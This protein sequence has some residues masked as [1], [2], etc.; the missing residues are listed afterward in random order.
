MPLL[1]AASQI[2]GHS[3]FLLRAVPALF[4]AA[5]VYTTCLLATEFGG[6]A[7]AELFAA[8]VAAITPVLM[9]FGTTITT[10]MVGLWLW[11]LAALCILRIVK[12]A[13]PRWWLAAGAIVG[14]A[15]ESKYSVTFFVAAVVVALLALPQRRVL[16][17]PWFFA[18]VALA[19]IIALPNFLWQA[20]HGYPMWTLLRD[21]DEYKNVQLTPLQYAATQILITHPLLAPV[22]LI[23][24]WTLLRRTTERF[25]G[26]AYLLLIAQISLLH[27]KHYY[28]GAVYPILI[29]AGAVSIER[30]TARSALWRPALAAYALVA[31]ILLVPLLMPVLPERTMSAYDRVAQSMLA[32]EVTLARTDGSTIGNLPPDWADMHG[33]R[34]LAAAVARVYHSLPPAQRA[35]AGILAS[36]YGEAAAID[37]FGAQYGLPPVISGHN[38]Y[39]IWGTRGYSGNVII[40]VHGECDRDARL[41]RTYRV[42]TH[43]SNPW[44]RPFENGFPISVCEGITTPLASFW[45]KLR[46]YN[47]I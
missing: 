23:G 26:V 29:A 22:W 16:A 24:L 36:N 10:D 6:A 38:Q 35:Q 11:P 42:A 3:L 8:L 47:Q 33:W 34:E 4:A 37:F 45:P 17:T 39:W 2:F 30:W 31:G 12:G 32:R 15:L 43:F 14:V 1:A 21:A 20:L 25:L 44:G 5:C 19:T 13:D 7:F 40:D 41:F 46:N 18:G 27:G 9:R 28:A